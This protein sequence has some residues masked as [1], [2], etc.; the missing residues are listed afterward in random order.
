[1]QTVS[2]YLAHIDPMLRAHAVWSARRLGLVG[3]LP[4][5]D[6]DASVRAE[7]GLP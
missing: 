5:T 1:M 3:L 4:D 7:L 6:P 2:R